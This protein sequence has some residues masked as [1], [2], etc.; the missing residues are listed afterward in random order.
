MDR[1]D[2]LRAMDDVRRR[3]AKAALRLG[4]AIAEARALADRYEV[5]PPFG[6]TA[7]T[8]DDLRKQAALCEWLAKAEIDKD[9]NDTDKIESLAGSLEA[10]VTMCQP[11]SREEE[12]KLREELAS[13]AEND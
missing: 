13:S 6:F 2:M 5:N 9:L 10:E 11:L 12:G 4:M 1:W 8:A 7:K 3:Q